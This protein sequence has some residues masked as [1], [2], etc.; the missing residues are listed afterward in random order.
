MRFNTQMLRRAEQ[1][2]FVR[3]EKIQHRAMRFGFPYRPPQ[4]VRRQA[5]QIEQAL[6]PALIRQYPAKSCQR[7]CRRVPGRCFRPVVNGRSP[8]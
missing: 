1:V 5:R 2:G 6:C 8:L 7:Q 4:A 3:A